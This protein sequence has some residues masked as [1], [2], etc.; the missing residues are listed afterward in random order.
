MALMNSTAGDPEKAP[1]AKALADELARRA[2]PA[3][4]DERPG[5]GE[6]PIGDASTM[7]KDWGSR[8]E[9]GGDLAKPKGSRGIGEN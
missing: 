4:Y 9:E 5:V 3:G 8:L 6:A 1:L 7:R 2:K